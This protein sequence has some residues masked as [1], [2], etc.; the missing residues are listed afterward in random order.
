MKADMS[1]TSPMIVD[2]WFLKV[3]LPC[4]HRPRSPVNLL[5]NA[6]LLST[7]SIQHVSVSSL[8]SQSISQRLV[9]QLNLDVFSYYDIQ[10]TLF[11]LTQVMLNWDRVKSSSPWDEAVDVSSTAVDMATITI[12]STHGWMVIVSWSKYSTSSFAHACCTLS[13]L[14]LQPVQSA[15]QLCV[16]FTTKPAM[17][18]HSTAIL[19]NKAFPSHLSA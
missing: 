14:W 10:S 9:Q 12:H 6:T 3:S 2:I 15:L 7:Y 16:H 5:S 8:D 4:S 11:Y 19:I 18:Q 13:N 1:R 17:L